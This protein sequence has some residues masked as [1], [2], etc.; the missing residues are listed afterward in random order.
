MRKGA[1]GDVK[2][3]GHGIDRAI[4]QH[5]IELQSR[6]LGLEGAEGI[7]KPRHRQRGR[8]LDAQMIDEIVALLAHARQQIG[9][10]GD[11][12]ARAMHVALAGLQVSRNWRVERMKQWRADPR[13]QL[14]D[15]LGDHRGR[16]IEFLAQRQEK[17]VAS[18]VAR[19]A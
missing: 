6:V 1:D 8:R 13:F 9:G 5:D 3:F 4:D 2:A 18:A 7:R 10:V 16:D 12:A 15:A 19:N 17:P 11:D 14:R